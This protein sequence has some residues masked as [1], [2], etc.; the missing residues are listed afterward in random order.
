MLKK[1]MILDT[2]YWQNMCNSFNLK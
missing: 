1:K 2:F